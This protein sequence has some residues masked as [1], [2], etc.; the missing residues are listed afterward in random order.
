M[1]T[2]NAALAD[3]VPT[4]PELLSGIVESTGEQA[5]IG[6]WS[7]DPDSGE[8]FW[9]RQTFRILGYEPDE[10][11]PTYDLFREALHDSQRDTDRKSVV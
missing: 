11:A 3:S 6:Y 7:F 2:E 5:S 1:G 9:S 10:V 8:V 4:N